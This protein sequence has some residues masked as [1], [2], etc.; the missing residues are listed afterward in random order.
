MENETRYYLVL[1]ISPVEFIEGFLVNDYDPPDGLLVRR[2]SETYPGEGVRLFAI[3]SLG[4]T[5]LLGAMTTEFYL[6]LDTDGEKHLITRFHRPT[7]RIAE[8]Y[9]VDYIDPAVIDEENG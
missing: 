9:Y 4:S 2:G 7:K 3:D 6:A 5:E 1:R 8:V